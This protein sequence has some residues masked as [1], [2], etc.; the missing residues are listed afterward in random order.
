MKIKTKL[1]RSGNSHYIP[2]DSEM[3]QKIIDRFGKRILCTIKGHTLHCAILN[4]KELGRY[5]MVSKTA[6]EKIK[7][8]Y[9]DELVLKISKD[10]SEYQ[11]EVSEEFQE[12]LSTDEEGILRFEKLTPGKKRSLIHYVGKAKNSDTRINRAIKIVEN[13]KMGMTDLRELLRS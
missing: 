8:E 6:K 13:L 4:K 1:D 3:G 7:A 9:G 2:I 12:V 11:M 10:T 5:I